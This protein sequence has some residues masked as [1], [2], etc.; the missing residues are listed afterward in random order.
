[1]RFYDISQN[2]DEWLQLRS[3]KVTSSKLGVIMANYGRTFGEPAKKYAVNIAIEQIT[4]KA[5]PSD[6]SNAHMERGHEQEPLARMEYESTF[7]CSVSNGGYFDCGD[8][9]A[10]PDGIVE[11]VNGAIE[12]KSVVPSTHYATISRGALDPG[13]K[14]QVIGTLS[15]CKFDWIDFVSYCQPFPEGKRIF[16]HRVEP[17]SVAEEIEK[18][19]IRLDEFNK[20][21][22]VVKEKIQSGEY[23]V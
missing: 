14:W 16:V 15:K 10:S 8:Y 9:G 13:Y 21:I 2:D 3:G 18:I 5:I 1:V 20:Y 11:G 7:F 17:S 4:G 19:E 23:F 22:E 6:Y 12:I